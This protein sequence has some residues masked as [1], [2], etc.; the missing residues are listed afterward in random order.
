MFKVST[1]QEIS[2]SEIVITDA[3][4]HSAEVNV[5]SIMY[6]LLQAWL[7]DKNLKYLLS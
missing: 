7:Q 3:V 1:G 4:D 5:P 6:H 2:Y